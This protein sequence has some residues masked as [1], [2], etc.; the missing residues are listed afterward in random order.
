MVRRFNQKNSVGDIDAIKDSRI[1][2]LISKS[3]KCQIALF[4]DTL[5]CFFTLQCLA[6]ANGKA[7]ILLRRAYN[8]SHFFQKQERR[9][10]IRKPLP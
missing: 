7:R 9:Q 5:F 1:R 2:A 3:V 8:A 6:L 10:V 4:M